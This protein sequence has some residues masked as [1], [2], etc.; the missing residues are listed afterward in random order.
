MRDC[1]DTEVAGFGLCKDPE[2]L[3]LVH[4]LIMVPQ[5]CSH[6]FVSLDDKGV[7]DMFDDMFDAGYHPQQFGR[8]WVHTH[9]K[10]SANP[11]Q[12]DEETFARVFGKTDW[13]VM[14]I[15]SKTED[16]YARLKF[17]VGPKA[18][19]K[20]PMEVDFRHVGDG[21]DYDAWW[22]EYLKNVSESQDVW[23]FGKTSLA[24]TSRWFDEE[25]A[26]GFLADQG[27]DR[28]AEIEERLEEINSEVAELDPHNSSDALEIDELAQEAQ[29]LINE[30][31]AIDIDKPDTGFLSLDT[32]FVDPG[33]TG[34]LPLTDE[35]MRQEIEEA[36]DR[37]SAPTEDVLG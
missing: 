3:M 11:S 25:E 26:T 8:I 35:A 18:A 24:K 6:A 36:E 21:S 29:D 33:Q 13:A 22:D 34:F 14:A 1:G 16:T 5:K 31:Q 12:T 4:D 9:P 7:A 10:M 28:L 19:F 37:Q 27:D 2:D 15:L 23:H 30:A 20:I 32:G 17:N